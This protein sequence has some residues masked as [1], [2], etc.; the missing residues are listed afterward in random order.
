MA[1]LSQRQLASCIWPRARESKISCGYA[2]VPR[3]EEYLVAPTE[4]RASWFRIPCVDRSGGDCIRASACRLRDRYLPANRSLFRPTRHIRPKK[5]ELAICCK[6]MPRCRL[7][8]GQDAVAPIF[9][10]STN[11]WKTGGLTKPIG[12]PN[13]F[14]DQHSTSSHSQ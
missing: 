7:E 12:H 14:K 6:R 10:W 11:A 5:R 13:H 3:T 1:F 2:G 9:R 4:G 8:T